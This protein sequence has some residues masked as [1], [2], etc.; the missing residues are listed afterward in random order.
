[1][2]SALP[3]QDHAPRELRLAACKARSGRE[4]ALCAAL[5]SP[6][7]EGLNGDRQEPECGGYADDYVHGSSMPL[8]A[9]SRHQGRAVL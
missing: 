4:R 8:R 9:G 2:I 1:M 3:K 7:L 6:V 5:P